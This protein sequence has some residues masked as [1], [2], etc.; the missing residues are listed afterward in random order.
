MSPARHATIRV[1]DSHTAG[2]PTRLVMDGGPQLGD[3]P[4][5]ERLRRFREHHDHFRRAI[6][7]EPRG[8]DTLVGALL[9]RPHRPDCQVGVIFFNNVGFLGMCGHGTIGLVASLASEGSCAPGP[10]RIDTP[11]GPVDARLHEDGGIDVVNVVSYRQARDVSV[12]LAGEAVHGD[13]AWGGNWFFLTH[14]ESVAIAPDNLESLTGLAARLR[15]AVNEQGFPLVDHVEI[16]GPPARAGASSRNFVLCPG[17]AYDRSP[18]GTGTSARLAC[19]AA[20]GELEEGAPWVQ[21]SLI[22]STFTGRYRWHD[23]DKGQIV[24]TITGR[25]YVTAESSLR[26]DPDD[27]FRWGV[28]AG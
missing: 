25:A 1:I 6:V 16:C 10:I 2:E 27:P 24:P 11:V 26:L 3:G 15:R 17:G 18:C 20:D 4:L 5:A 7:N 22:G 12:S 19:L 23:R 28:V 14:A 9:C 21:E 13:V 8:S